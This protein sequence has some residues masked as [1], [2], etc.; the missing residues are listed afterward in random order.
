MYWFE[1]CPKHIESKYELLVF[2]ENHPFL[3]LTVCFNASNRMNSEL[4]STY[5]AD[6]YYTQK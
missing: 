6:L 5:R 3:P 4:L 2:K 1:Y